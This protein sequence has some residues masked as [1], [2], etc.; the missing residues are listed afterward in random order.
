MEKIIYAIKYQIFLNHVIV[1]L[2]KK[3]QQLLIL[4]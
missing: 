3:L 4:I 2:M 1:V